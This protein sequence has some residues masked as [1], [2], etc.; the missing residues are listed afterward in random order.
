MMKPLRANSSMFQTL[1]AFI[2]ANPG[3]ARK[4]KSTA[5]DSQEYRE[6]LERKFIEGR[7]PRA[8]EKPKTVPDS[9]VSIILEDYFGE[10][11]SD[12]EE[13]K[14]T[15]LLAMAAENTVGDLLE[16][17]LASVLESHG[18]VWCSG[19]V[20]KS[21]DFIK[22]NPGQSP[23]WVCLQVKNRDNSEN[24]S[25]S[26]VRNGTNIEKWFRTFSRTGK[27]NWDKFPDISARNQLSESGFRNFVKNYIKAI[28][29]SASER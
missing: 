25:A 11:P 9:V 26:A 20:T 21:I 14:R 18:W 29:S 28:N 22:H 8:P 19:S 3:S 16:R 13:I 6:K 1:V 17:Y 27:T 24:S 7:S 23:E 12:I 4:F 10:K 5:I 2:S 15:H